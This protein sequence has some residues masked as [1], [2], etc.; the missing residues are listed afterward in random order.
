M[1]IESAIEKAEAWLQLDGVE[2][3]AQGEC[4]GRHCVLVLSSCPPEM[5][6]EQVPEVI[7]GF[8]VVIKRAGA[9]SAGRT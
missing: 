2:G 7:L 9:L 8:P 3:V 4:A 6:R 1:S 5:L